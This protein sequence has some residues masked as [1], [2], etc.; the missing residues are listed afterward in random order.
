[1]N[2]CLNCGKIIGKNFEVCS[3]KCA[4]EYFKYVSG[5]KLEDHPEFKTKIEGDENRKN[6]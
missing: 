6:S 4:K 3:Q 5:E 1:M 2:K